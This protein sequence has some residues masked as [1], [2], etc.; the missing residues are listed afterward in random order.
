MADPSA[1]PIVARAKKLVVVAA[2]AL[3]SL[4]VLQRSGIG[5]KS[6]LEALGI[7][8]V[9]DLNRVGSNYQDHNAIFY[10]YSSKATAEE[11][12]DGL[13]TGRLTFEKAVEQKAANSCFGGM[14]STAS[15]SFG[16]PTQKFR[17]LAQH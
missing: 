15:E 12:L 7:P 14:A 9:S 8:V 17:N 3:G 11:T 16:P 10:S 1:D 6:K 13:L 5:N 2:N 4:Q